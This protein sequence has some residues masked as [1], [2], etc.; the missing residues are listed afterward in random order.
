V[1]L[2]HGELPQ[3]TG[4]KT[5]KDFEKLRV[6]GMG[7]EVAEEEDK[8]KRKKIVEFSKGSKFW[9]TCEEK[10][11]RGKSRKARRSKESRGEEE[12]KETVES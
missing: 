10:K 8:K 9:R 12:R 6:V 3:L 4:E 2:R 11:G 7:G 5:A 1:S